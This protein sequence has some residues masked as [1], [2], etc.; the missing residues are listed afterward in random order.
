MKT[1]HTLQD[2]LSAPLSPTVKGPLLNLLTDLVVTG[3]SPS[4]SRPSDKT[5]TF[6]LLLLEPEDDMDKL[7]SEVQDQVRFAF[8]SAEQVL[9]LPDGYELRVVVTDDL[10]GG[11]FLMTS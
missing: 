9:P 6:T 5:E 7:E 1:L 2:V 10:G 8:E 4:S 3:S 11:Y